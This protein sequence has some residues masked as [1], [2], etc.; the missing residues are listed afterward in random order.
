MSEK[1]QIDLDA[2]KKIIA[3]VIKEIGLDPDE[4][5]NRQGNFWTLY[6]GSAMVYITLYTIDRPGEAPEWYI[7]WSSPVMQIPSANLLAFYRRLLEENA[8]RVALK[9][10]L[11]EDT[12]WMEISRELE[13]M[14]YNE[15]YRNLTRIGEAA[16]ELDDLL[17]EEF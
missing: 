8:G 5:Y 7:E 13:G 6:K 10:S 1:A 14:S 15:C 11:R 17:K 16:D 3:D 2:Y 12:V 4:C 9:F